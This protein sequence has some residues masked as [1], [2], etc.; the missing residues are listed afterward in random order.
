MDRVNII[1]RVERNANIRERAKAIAIEQSVEVPLAAITKQRVLDEIVGRVE[2]IED[3][4]DGAHRV[5]IS[6]ATETIG[7]ET[8]QLMSM[9][10]GN[11]SLAEDVQILDVDLP[12]DLLA[13]FPGP[14]FGIDGLRKL[15]QAHGRPLTCTALKPQGLDSDELADLAYRLALGGLDMIKD[16][17]GITDQAYSPFAERVPKIQAAVARANRETGGHCAYVPSVAG[18]P[19]KLREHCRIVKEEGVDAVLLIPMII[20]LPVFQEMTA[21]WLDVPV[22]AHPGFGGAQRMAPPL[23][24]GKLLRLFGADAV[25]FVNHLGRFT[26]PRATCEATAANLTGAMRHVKPALPVPAGGMTLDRVPDMKQ[27][28]GEDAM[29]LIGGGL[30][31]ARDNLLARCREF[32]E[33]VK[34][35]VAA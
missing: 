31:T 17:H 4:P 9:I 28:Y 10:Y 3:L 23:F 11:I 20:G 13:A 1:Y 2:R 25:I 7:G 18:G 8:A 6:L 5:T 33:M 15:T 34:Q 29:F 27:S 22:L 16:D 21:E 35:P 12:D 26:W 32:V 30:L 19:R 14:R 24:F